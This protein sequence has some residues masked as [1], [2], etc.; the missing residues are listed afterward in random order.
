MLRTLVSFRTRHQPYMVRRNYRRELRS[1]LTYPLAGALAEGS[2]T[3]I[4]AAKYFQATPML[5]AVITAAPMFGNIVALIWSEMAKTRRKVRMVNWLQ[6]GVVGSIAAISLTAT[7]PRQT[8]AWVFAAL[9]ILARLL[10]SGIVTIRSAIWRYNY[11]RHMRGQ[12][13]GR[14]SSVATAVTA[15]ATLAGAKWLDR[16]PSAY[17]YLYPMAAL[18]GV[19]GIWQ[20]SG[21]RVRREGQMLKRLRDPI[22]IPRP[23]SM[24]TTDEANVLNDEPSRRAGGI[25]GFLADAVHVLRNDRQFRLY[26]W[27]Q[28]LN[29]AA[30][31]MMVPPLTIMVS[32]QMTDPQKQYLLATVVLQI[33]PMVTLILF[34]QV[35]APLFDRV[36]VSVFRVFQGIVSA[37]AIATVMSGSL[38]GSLLAVAV[39]QFLV[40]V[41][42]AAGNLAWN[43]GHNDFA[44]RDQAGTYMGLHV[45]LTGL[46]GCMAPFAGALLFRDDVLGRGVF[47][48]SLG[49][50]VVSLVGFMSMARHA[51]SKQRAHSRARP[52]AR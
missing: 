17:V 24:S 5:I 38:W 43:L 4:V 31:M 52:M 44:P 41:S 27:W 28:F 15:F 16:D 12:I 3:G 34:T 45:M 37:I 10:A 23:E 30:F 13:V 22:A 51:P 21:I 20:F 35:W 25:A 6:A 18:L 9:V 40:G 29:G 19:V 7:L 33:V 1:A 8:G 46:R 2:F 42:H 26:Q 48:V 50:S 14:I 32:K 11:P 36:H 47:A 49:L 39:G